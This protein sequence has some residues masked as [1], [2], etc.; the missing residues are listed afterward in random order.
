MNKYK[1]VMVEIYIVD[2]KQDLQIKNVNIF[3]DQSGLI[4]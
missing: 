4:H 2:I 3:K 1:I